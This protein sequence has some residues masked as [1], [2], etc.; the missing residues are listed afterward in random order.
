MLLDSR[1]H[2]PFNS[3]DWIFEIKNDGH[4]MLAEFDAGQVVIR[5]RGGQRAG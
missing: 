3:P 4:R 5:P 1:T 2:A